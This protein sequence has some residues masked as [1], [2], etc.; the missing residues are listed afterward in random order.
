MLNTPKMIVFLSKLCLKI[1]K[2]TSDY[3][4]EF[5]AS[6]E[7]AILPNYQPHKLKLIVGIHNSSW[8][9]VNCKLFKCFR[10]NA[11]ATNVC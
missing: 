2:V 1:Q 9:K 10:K 11:H 6:Q 5:N 7:E 8:E 3:K 4:T